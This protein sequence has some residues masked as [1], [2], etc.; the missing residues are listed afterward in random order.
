MNIPVTT[1]CPGFVKTEITTKNKRM[2]FVLEADVAARKMVDAIERRQK[3]YCFP[4]RLRALIWL[5]KWAPDW[6]MARAVPD[7][8]GGPPGPARG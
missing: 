8:V 4:W 7:A 5:T 3:V 1:I 2:M 6:V